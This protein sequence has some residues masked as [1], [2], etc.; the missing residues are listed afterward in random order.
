VH[1]LPDQLPPVCAEVGDSAVDECNL[2][3]EVVVGLLLRRR[4]VLDADR[5]HARLAHDYKT[6]HT[7]GALRG[8]QFGDGKVTSSRRTDA[9][10]TPTA[11]LTHVVA[12]ATI[13]KR[14][15]P[16]VYLQSAKAYFGVWTPPDCRSV[17]RVV[18]LSLSRHLRVHALVNLRRDRVLAEVRPMPARP[19]SGGLP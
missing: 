8:L 5:P 13:V 1:D 14:R 15:E 18:D 16:L 10:P 7:I 12:S 2:R 9:S 3:V 4:S 6:P 17:R 19:Q 11:P